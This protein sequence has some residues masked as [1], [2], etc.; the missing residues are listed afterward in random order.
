MEK[1]DAPPAF[2]SRN[3]K[4]V[5]ADFD[6]DS[7]RTVFV[8]PAYVLESVKAGV[9]AVHAILSDTTSHIVPV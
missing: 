6:V 2:A 9:F 8:K 5:D 1:T 3:L 4:S 7:S